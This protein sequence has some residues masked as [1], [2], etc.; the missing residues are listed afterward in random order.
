MEAESNIRADARSSN[1]SETPGTP[2]MT[3]EDE[4]YANVSIA[5]SSEASMFLTSYGLSYEP[6]FSMSVQHLMALE[7][8]PW[9]ADISQ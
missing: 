8:N 6:S 3:L 2:P 5:D 9:D 1:V 7:V 4:E